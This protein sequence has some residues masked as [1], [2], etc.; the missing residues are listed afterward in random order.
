MVDSQ[1]VRR[2][3]RDP[4]SQKSAQG[5]G[6]I[7]KDAGYNLV[8]VA[9]MGDQEAHLAEAERLWARLSAES[10]FKMKRDVR[11]LKA[12][13]EML[14]EENYLDDILGK[15]DF[16]PFEASL[17]TAQLHNTNINNLK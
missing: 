7:L 6:R 11:L 17:D 3:E 8:E 2:S 12:T 14:N 10:S 16:A 13:P 1:A 15:P 9:P 4:I 5:K